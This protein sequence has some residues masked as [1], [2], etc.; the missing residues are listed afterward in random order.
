MRIFLFCAG[1]K[2]WRN[3]KKYEMDLGENSDKIPI[4]YKVSYH[5]KH[6][7]AICCDFESWEG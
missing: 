4:H 7:L 2:N 6:S 3:I 5:T 1:C